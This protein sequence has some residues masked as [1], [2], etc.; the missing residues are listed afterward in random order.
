ML[1]ASPIW[2]QAANVHL[3]KLDIVERNT[4]RII[5][6]KD[7]RDITNE[8]LYEETGQI[9]IREVILNKTRA[10]FNSKVRQDPFT[11]EIG[12]INRE[13]AH[14]RKIHRLI[15]DAII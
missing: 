8:Q 5:Q 7:R 2:S 3:R 12:A 13:N 14:F 4:L 1:Y 15:T 9:P 10:F 11:R 6:N